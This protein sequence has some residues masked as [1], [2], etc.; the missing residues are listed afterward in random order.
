MRRRRVV[1][2]GREAV[3]EL[4]GDHRRAE[5]ARQILA[6][7]H[8]HPAAFAERQTLAVSRVRRRGLRRERLEGVEAGV[9][10]TGERLGA[11]GEHGV[12]LA[13]ADQLGGVADRVRARRAGGVDRDDGPLDVER[14]GQLLRDRLGRGQQRE[15][16]VR[17]LAR[18]VQMRFEQAADLRSPPPRRT[19][20]DRNRDQQARQ[21]RDDG[22][23]VPTVHEPARQQ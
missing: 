15:D 23:G 22:H 6:H 10:D 12:G 21:Q 3:P 8:H 19:G 14:R 18:L 2:V 20:S 1:P 13:V 17:V 7:Q 5:L 11:P 9:K 16:G 4:L